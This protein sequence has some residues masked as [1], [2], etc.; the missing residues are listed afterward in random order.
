MQIPRVTANTLT[1]SLTQTLWEQLLSLLELC[2]S[3]QA[4]TLSRWSTDK[5]RT[6]SNK[7]SGQGLPSSEHSQ[8]MKT[9]TSQCF[10]TEVAAILILFVCNSVVEQWSEQQ[11]P[12]GKRRPQ[13][14][15]GVPAEEWMP[16]HQAG[17][18]S[19]FPNKEVHA[20]LAPYGSPPV[21]LLAYCKK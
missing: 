2:S 3:R 18:W 16:C 12:Y 9:W 1:K 11:L 15:T 17:D 21:R 7:L 4:R 19:T 10:I 13:E 14:R 6:S 8:Q 20:W 5:C